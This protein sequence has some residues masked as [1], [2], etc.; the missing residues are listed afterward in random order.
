M[1][2]QET[3][4]GDWNQV[5]GKLRS[6]WG[7][8]SNSEMQ[9]YKG[10][11]SQLVGYIQRKTGESIDK[12]ERFI[13]DLSE[14]RGETVGP[15]AEAIKDFASQA[16]ETAK[17]GAEA[18]ADHARSGYEAAERLVKE[19]PASSVGVAFGAGLVVGILL[20]LVMGSQR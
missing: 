13:N 18:I 14:N 20:S 5:T 2:N 15:A 8:L 6:K 12:I 16:V 11:A 7:Q 19:R 1:V 17:Q 3:L 10:D 9:Q 4:K